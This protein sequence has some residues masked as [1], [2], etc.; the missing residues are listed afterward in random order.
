MEGLHDPPPRA[1]ETD[2]EYFERKVLE[3]L[4]R[5]PDAPPERGRTG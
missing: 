1:R 5:I 2:D 3:A 4:D